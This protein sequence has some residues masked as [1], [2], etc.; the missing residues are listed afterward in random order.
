MAREEGNLTALRVVMSK[1]G[2]LRSVPTLR[3]REWIMFVWTEV[4]LGWR[5][6]RW[7]L[8]LIV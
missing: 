5:V 7:C 8:G 2:G 4:I 6:S 3:S 1:P